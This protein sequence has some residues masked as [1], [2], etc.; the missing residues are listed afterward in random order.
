MG[1]TWNQA[2]VHLSSSQQREQLAA[3]VGEICMI[4]V[5]TTMI[6]MS[7]GHLLNVSLQPLVMHRRMPPLSSTVADLLIT[8]RSAVMLTMPLCAGALRRRTWGSNQLRK[9]AP[10]IHLEGP[11]S[12][13]PESCSRRPSVCQSLK[14]RNQRFVLLSHRV[15]GDVRCLSFIL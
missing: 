11:D 12:Q 1:T 7:R 9:N 15:S 8:W 4:Y 6:T 3:L 5:H 2:W 10:R 13:C 14:K